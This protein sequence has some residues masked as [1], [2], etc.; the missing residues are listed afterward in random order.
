MKLKVDD[1]TTWNCRLTNSRSTNNNYNIKEVL[2][3]KEE[4][5]NLITIFVR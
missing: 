1:I 2:K 4:F 3:E 5:I